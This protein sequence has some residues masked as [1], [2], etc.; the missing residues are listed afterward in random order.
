MD[1]EEPPVYLEEP[2]KITAEVTLSEKIYRK[3]Y[4]IKEEEEWFDITR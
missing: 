1:D 2:T 3:I 4:L